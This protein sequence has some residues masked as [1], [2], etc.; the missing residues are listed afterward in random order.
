MSTARQNLAG[1]PM[2]R[3][4]LELWLRSPRGRRLLALEE[5]EARR[6]LPEVFGRHVLQVGSWGFDNQ[7][8]ASA[9]TLH[10]AVLGTV[11]GESSSS[12]LIDPEQLPLMSKSVDA[13]LLP[14]TLE[15]SRSPHNVLREVNRV[16][17]DRGRLFVM[18]F[19]PWSMWAL[20]GRLG[21]RYRAFPAGAR[22][23]G[24]GR[25]CDWLELLDFEIAEVRRFG[26]GFPWMAPRTSGGPWSLGALLA[27][28]SESYMVVAR[29]RVIPINLIGRT[30]RAQVRPLVGV[31]AP[32]AQSQAS[33]EKHPT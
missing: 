8:V 33:L 27:P 30:Q 31:A 28:L 17:N 21:L 10:K 12:A 13:V 3:H 15:F 1:L 26:L 2:S 4:T 18:G 5:A 16:L 19:S 14:H 9:E 20:R 11:G 29:K 6:V 24:V 23:H 32:A 22:F 25:I 7:L